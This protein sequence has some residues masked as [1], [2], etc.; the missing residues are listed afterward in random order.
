MDMH[1]HTFGK[2]AAHSTHSG[3]WPQ[4]MQTGLG[5]VGKQQTWMLGPTIFYTPKRERK[6]ALFY[7]MDFLSCAL[8]KTKR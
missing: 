3:C 8:W 4:I 2:P 7:Y 6:I 1:E 5:D